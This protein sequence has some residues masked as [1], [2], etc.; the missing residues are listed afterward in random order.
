VL[1]LDR[2][3]TGSY[4]MNVND[5]GYPFMALVEHTNYMD[6]RDYG[7]RHLVY[8][9]NYRPMDDPL[10]RTPTAE[11][12]A[13]FSP[14]LQRINPRFDPSWIHRCLEL[15]GAIR[16]AYRDDRLPRPHPTL[17]DAGPRPLGGEHVPDLS[18]RPG[19]ELLESSWPNGSLLDY[20]GS[21]ATFGATGDVVG[22]SRGCTSSSPSI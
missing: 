6:R 11:V 17:R 22:F 1:A 14:H 21:A 3:L 10:L 15:L 20:V 4:W 9:G 7:G 19:A 2:P 5:P 18:A 16:A 12:V 13:E 8:L